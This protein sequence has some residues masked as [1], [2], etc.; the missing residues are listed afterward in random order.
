MTTLS[1]LCYESNEQV[2]PIFPMHGSDLKTLLLFKKK[3]KR[4]GKTILTE[5]IM[6]HNKEGTKKEITQPSQLKKKHDNC[7]TLIE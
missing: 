3:K 6:Q 7:D 4:K 5:H 1:Y 2:P